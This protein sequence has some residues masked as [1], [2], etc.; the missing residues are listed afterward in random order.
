[1]KKV[2][3]ILFVLATCVHEVSGQ[4]IPQYTQWSY[5]QFAGN[6][7]HAGIKRCVDIHTL[8]R[9]Q[10]VGFDG[11]PQSGFLTVS[12]PLDAKRRKY[13]SA[14]HGTGLRFENDRIGQF[15]FN[16]INLAYAGHFNFTASRRLS[17]GIF[18]GAVQ[19]GYNPSTVQTSSP[20]PSVSKEGSFVAP[21]ASFGAWFNDENYYIGLSLQNLIPSPWPSIGLDSRFR[22]HAQLN[23]GYRL[24][25]GEKVSLLPSAN[26]RIPPRGPVSVDLNLHL[27]YKNL[28][29]FGVGYRNTDALMF[30]ASLKIKEQFSIVYSFD[31]TLSAIQLGAQNTHEISLRFTTCKPDRQS[32]ASCPLFE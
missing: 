9:A 19:M 24:G 25:I 13:L 17:L 28:L 8:Y 7:A 31:Y 21:D 29:G 2:L 14:R 3:Y 15:G 20:D 12:V 22:I 27:D 32:T 4:Q 1:M 11:A 16:R 23:G 26:L 6:P 18:A 30:F 5:H 10:W